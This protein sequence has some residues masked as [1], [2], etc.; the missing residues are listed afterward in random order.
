MKTAYSLIYKI[1]IENLCLIAGFFLTAFHFLNGKIPYNHS[2]LDF[3]PSRVTANL[4]KGYFATSN[5]NKIAEMRLMNNI[6]KTHRDLY[7][8]FS[9]SPNWIYVHPNQKSCAFIEYN[10]KKI[11]STIEFTP[12][13]VPD[14][15]KKIKSESQLQ[16]RLDGKLVKSL[17]IRTLDFQKKKTINFSPFRKLELRFCKLKEFKGSG[18]I[19][20]NPKVF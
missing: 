5:K 13:N 9:H 6:R 1:R 19:L 8:K 4:K 16:I 15:N 18:M 11:K 12:Y 14:P 2:L 20:L 7:E 17:S 3:Q 10:F